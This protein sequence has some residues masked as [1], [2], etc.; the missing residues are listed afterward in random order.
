MGLRSF[1][2]R[3]A[4]ADRLSS[5]GPVK[6]RAYWD[7]SPMSLGHLCEYTDGEETG[8][9]RMSLHLLPAPACLVAVVVN[10]HTQ[11]P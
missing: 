5:D 11:K 10:R 7:M 3:S 9:S 1:Q 8:T 4:Q 2:F 6:P